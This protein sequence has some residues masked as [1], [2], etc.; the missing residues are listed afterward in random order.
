M[1]P[2]RVLVWLSVCIL[3]FASALAYP[4]LPAEI[5]QHISSAGK[6]TGFVPRSP[7][8]WGFPLVIAVIGIAFVDLLTARIPRRVELFN[9]PGKEQLLKLPEEY[10]TETV[11]LMQRFM[12]YVNLQLVLTFAVVQW[13]LWRGAHGARTQTETIALLVLSPALVVFAGLY[14]QK[15]Q[16]AVDDAQRRYDSR[17]NPLKS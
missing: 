4:G 10:R 11:R 9:F 7:L 1:R 15:I 17:R 8:A 3:V 12:D 14:I 2:T 5:P 16:N 13:M 6:S